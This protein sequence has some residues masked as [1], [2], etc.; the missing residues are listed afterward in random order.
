MILYTN[1]LIPPR[2]QAITYGPLIVIRPSRK[3]DEGLLAHERVHV[4]QF[5]RN[6]FFGLA[7]LFSKKKR[8]QYEVEA[9]RVQLKY[10]PDRLGAFANALATKYRLGITQGEAE[11]LLSAP[12]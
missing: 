2:F 11:L 5:K 6:P 8:L 7:Y 3:G 12:E 1:W 9:Y 10:H 4:E